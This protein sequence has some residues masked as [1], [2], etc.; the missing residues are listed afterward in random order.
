MSIHRTPTGSYRVKWRDPS[1]R[2]RSKN[3]P[4]KRAAR[5]FLADIHG[6]ISRGRYVDPHAGRVLFRVHAHQ[7]L[8]SRNDE[9]TTK[10]R[11]ASIMRNHVLR[12]WGDWPLSKI[13]HLSVQSWVTDLGQRRSPATVAEAHR[14]TAAV[15]KSAV[16]NRLIAYN[17]CEGIRLP[18]RRKHDN[19][20]RVITRDDVLTRLL[21]AAPDRYRAIIAT[22]AGTGL[23]W[24]EAAGLCDD[25]LDLDAATL[26]VV[27][28]V[29][30]VGGH[31]A[32]KLYPKSDASRRTVPLPHWLAPIISDHRARYARGVHQLLYPNQVG[33]P[34][35]RTLFRARV[36]RPTLV[37]AGLLGSVTEIAPQRYEG[38][39]TDD[40][41][42]LVTEKF[43]THGQAVKHVARHATG[44]LRF[45][46]LRHSYATWLVD[47]EVPPNMV[48][49]VMGHEHV[50]TTLQL[51]VRR[52]EHHDRIREALGIHDN[53]LDQADDDEGDEG[54]GGTAGVLV[55]I[56]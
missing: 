12:Q 28:T 17:P 7:W 37:R 2:Q 27:R 4:T 15:L 20:E 5:D 31:T 3:L 32:F 8:A 16:R 45:H 48:Q 25:A 24:G 29:V 41:S 50:A 22:A 21:P 9:A 36:W 14:L 52:T 40:A 26:R 38:Q 46:D 54:E 35:R 18:R 34:L 44:A 30:E 42:Q 53:Q 6:S 10:A 23:R 56:G 19:D 33:K 51:Y 47:D 13:D 39:W 1:G 11:D 49:R 55:P 43:R